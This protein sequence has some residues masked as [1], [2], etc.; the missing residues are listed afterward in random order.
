MLYAQHSMS[1][2]TPIP[3]LKRRMLPEIQG[4]NIYINVTSPAFLRLQ[5]LLFSYSKL[6]YAASHAEIFPLYFRWMQRS[7]R[8]LTYETKRNT[9]SSWTLSEGIA[10]SCACSS[11]FVPM[12]TLS[13][14]YSFVGSTVAWCCPLCQAMSGTYQR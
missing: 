5:R 12:A 3:H 8:P 1:F 10:S 7:L 14:T 9:L 11:W 6:T 2:H 13:G 4:Y